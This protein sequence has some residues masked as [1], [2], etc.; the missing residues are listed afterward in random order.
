MREYH[1]RLFRLELILTRATAE[2]ST[3]YI[4]MFNV[5]HLLKGLDWFVLYFIRGYLCSRGLSYICPGSYTNFCRDPHEME[6]TLRVCLINKPP[7][8][9]APTKV[10]HVHLCFPITMP[11]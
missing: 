2:F 8:A 1:L 7:D 9:E 4:H 6:G 11:E 5:S 3:T 10:L